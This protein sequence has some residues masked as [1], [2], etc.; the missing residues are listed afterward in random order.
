M[1][2]APTA[3]VSAVDDRCGLVREV[4][5]QRLHGRLYSC[6]ADLADAD[7]FGIAAGN[8]TVAGADWHDPDQAQR[9]AVGE[10]LERY[11]A[12]QIP[13]DRLVWGRWT[14][15]TGAVDPNMQVL[16]SAT[17][18][19][20]PGFPFTGLHRDAEHAWTRGSDPQGRGVLVPAGLVW[21]SP[22][23]HAELAG[24]PT[25]LPIA[26]GLAAG[27]DPAS[28]ATTAGQ[29]PERAPG[30]SGDPTRTAALAELVER[31]ALA[32]AWLAGS[33]FPPLSGPELGPGPVP[34]VRLAWHQ[35]P[36]RWR[37]PVVLCSA[38]GDDGTLGV[39]C[40]LKPAAADPVATAA[41]ASAAEAVQALHTV[42]LV[43]AGVP[44]W[45]QP[46]GPLRP[47]RPDREYTA[48]YAAD[49]HDI[50][51]LTCHLQL[52]ADPAYAARVTRRLTSGPSTGAPTGHGWSPQRQDLERVLRADGL[53]P[54]TVD[55]TTSDVSTLDMRV[56]RV[57]VP[58]LR[59]TT[60]G[61]FPQLMD[62]IDPLPATIE[63]TVIPLA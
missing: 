24:R 23:P 13:T 40:A 16:Y 12:T 57:L 20:R 35:V 39:G 11:C 4:R 22:G 42:R 53:T 7:P 28:A 33:S 8:P 30:D 18:R 2:G 21:L 59:S 5:M 25:N 37:A 44:Q 36:N 55:V 9:R 50:T 15:L 41:A 32:T 62:G 49:G 10:A 47:H 61:A 6:F 34:G 3:R 27:P 48:A 17:Q 63:A 52:L 31:H 29:R 58:G 14:E 43:T 1:H 38:H 56:L 51:D 45:E 26:A 54:I 19:N 60:P 46:V